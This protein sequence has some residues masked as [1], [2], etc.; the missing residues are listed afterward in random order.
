[1]VLVMAAVLQYDLT[2]AHL[3]MLLLLLCQP[4]LHPAPETT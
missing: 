2:V 4:L 3:G 1:M